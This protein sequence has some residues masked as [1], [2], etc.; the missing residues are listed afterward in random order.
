M[1]VEFELFWMQMHLIL[2]RNKNAASS[3]IHLHNLY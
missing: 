2:L 3:D 1:Y